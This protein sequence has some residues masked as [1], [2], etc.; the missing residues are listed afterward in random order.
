MFSPKEVMTFACCPSRC[1]RATWHVCWRGVLKVS[2]S[3]LLNAANLGLICFE[4]PANLGL[5]D[6]CLSVEADLTSPADVN[7]ESKSRTR[8]ILRYS[9]DL[10]KLLE[11][12]G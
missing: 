12:A 5:R 1:E 3:I 7:T 2:S 9:G 6:W 11:V 4:L 8:G 10:D